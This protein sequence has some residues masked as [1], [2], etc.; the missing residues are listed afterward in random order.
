MIVEIM[1][2][3]LGEAWS[4]HFPMVA[5]ISI[6]SIPTQKLKS[7]SPRSSVVGPN[8]DERSMVSIQSE[9]NSRYSIAGSSVHNNEGQG[10]S[11]RFQHLYVGIEK[12]KMSKN[13][14]G[15]GKEEL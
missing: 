9:R 14:K 1:Y 11:Y 15:G 2:L 7:A 8:D 6:V 3:R 4:H 13:K 5:M 12:S 10:S